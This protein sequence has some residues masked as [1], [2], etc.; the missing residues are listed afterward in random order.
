MG[1]STL[2]AC[3]LSM[4]MKQIYGETLLISPQTDT[5]TLVDDFEPLKDGEPFSQIRY[6]SGIH[7]TLSLQK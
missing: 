2:K 3:E 4:K 7:I 5:I 6:N 1:K